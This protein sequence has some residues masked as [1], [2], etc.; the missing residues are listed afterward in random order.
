MFIL[1]R[2]W[3]ALKFMFIDPVVTLV[4]DLFRQSPVMWVFIG[5]GWLSVWV[6]IFSL[7]DTMSQ[8]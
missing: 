2:I 3:G 6:M 8:L 4:G 5:W 7:V 1:N